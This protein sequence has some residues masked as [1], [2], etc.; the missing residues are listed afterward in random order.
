MRKTYGQGVCIGTDSV[1]I[2]CAVQEDGE[3]HVKWAAVAEVLPVYS[4][5]LHCM[6]VVGA[7]EDIGNESTA[8]VCLS[9]S[10]AVTSPPCFLPSLSPFL[11][12]S[13]SPFLPLTLSHSLP[14]AL[15]SN[16]NMKPKEGEITSR[17]WHWPINLQVTPIINPLYTS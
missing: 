3:P 2:V 14:L 17:P 5:E 10:F 6:L 8:L 12:P 13:L 1:F 16:N 11:P 9:L 7:V 4:T 15:Q